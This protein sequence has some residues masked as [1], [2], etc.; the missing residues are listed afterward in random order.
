MSLWL[1]C[2]VW[3]WFGLTVGFLLGAFW[4]GRQVDYRPCPAAEESAVIL[5]VHTSSGAGSGPLLE[6]H[7]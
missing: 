2:L 1:M 7:F 4:G 5:C 6:S 3:A